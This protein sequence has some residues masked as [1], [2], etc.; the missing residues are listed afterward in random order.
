MTEAVGPFGGALNT[1][2]HGGA[3]GNVREK[4]PAMAL[5]FRAECRL[6]IET[7]NGACK[8]RENL[9]QFER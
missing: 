2:A 4:V 9:I 1:R 6:G 8:C 7:A 5:K 3:K